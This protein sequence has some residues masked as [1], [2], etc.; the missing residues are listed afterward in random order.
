[1]AA[2]NPARPV[3][4]PYRLEACVVSLEQAV[5]AAAQGADRLEICRDLETEGLTPDIHLVREI[6]QE[7]SIPV[8]ILIRR[9]PV[10][11]A[12]DAKTLKDMRTDL[13]AF[14]ALPVEGYVFGI[15]RDGRVDIPAME[16]LLGETD[17]RPCTFHKAIDVSSN[18][19]EDLELLNALTGVDTVLTSGGATRA[20]TGIKGIRQISSAFRREVMGA[21]K[22]LPEDL[23]PLHDALQL[24][25]YHGRAIVGSLPGA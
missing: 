18:L 7:I 1:M 6:C 5:R 21:G 24:K 16:A 14:H 8:R 22:I 20:I 17:G 23:G 10:G 25:W 19:A 15:L 13:R 3:G 9:T 4:R 11:Y 12:A 2:I